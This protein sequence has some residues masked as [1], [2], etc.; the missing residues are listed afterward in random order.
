MND[1]A[2]EVDGGQVL[3][4]GI[5]TLFCGQWGATEIVD[6]VVWHNCV[7]I[8]LSHPHCIQ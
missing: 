2:K 4:G 5:G 8:C 1:E 3:C 6:I 7:C